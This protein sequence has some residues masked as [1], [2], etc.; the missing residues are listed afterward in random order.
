FIDK[1]NKLVVVSYRPTVSAKNGETNND[2]NLVQYPS[3]PIG[4]KVHQG[5]LRY[6]YSIQFPTQL[7][8]LSL[9]KSPQYKSYMLHITGF[10]LGGSIS[11]ISTPMWSKL[12]KAHHLTNKLRVFAYSNPRPGN[13]QFTKALDSLAIPIIRYARSG[14]VVPQVPLQKD[15]YTQMGAAFYDLGQSSILQCSTHLVEDLKCNTNRNLLDPK[16][17]FLP[18]GDTLPP[19]PFCP[20]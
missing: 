17:H 19:P 1:R 20:V 18:F 14:D 3:L 2:L 15:G 10:S 6:L 12:L 9:L 8:A 16:A 5:H 7:A 4:V 13:L 11:A